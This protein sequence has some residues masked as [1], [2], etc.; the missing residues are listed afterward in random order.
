VEKKEG[1]KMKRRIVAFMLALFLT[2]CVGVLQIT[3]AHALT[4]GPTWNLGPINTIGSMTGITDIYGLTYNQNHMV[5]GVALN[6]SV[7]STH[8]FALNL[9]SHG[10]YYPLTAMS[11]VTDLG[12]SP[13][14]YWFTPAPAQPHLLGGDVLTPGYWPVYTT[15]GTGY[16]RD[17]AIYGGGINWGSGPALI[18]YDIDSATFNVL[19]P[20]NGV[21]GFPSWSSHGAVFAVA[22]GVDGTIY[23]GTGNY[24]LGGPGFDYL[25]SYAPASGTFSY[26]GSAPATD[27]YISQIVTGLHGELYVLSQPSGTVLIF[28][29]LT[30]Q[31]TPF[32][33]SGYTAMTL[34]L[35][36]NLWLCDSSGNLYEY[37]P[38]Y[39]AITG[40][41][42]IT[43]LGTIVSPSTP[44]L[45]VYGMA[46]GLHGII[47]MAAYDGTNGY[48][49]VYDA[50]K[51]VGWV[52]GPRGTNG[53]G[54]AVNPATLLTTAGE[55]QY[56]LVECSEQ[57]TV[58]GGTGLSTSVAALLYYYYES[59]NPDL[60]NAGVVGGSALHLLA[61]YWASDPPA[62]S[63][64]STRDTTV[65]AFAVG[66]G[67]AACA[68]ILG[69]RKRQK[70]KT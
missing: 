49:V 24:L 59:G 44:T 8:L 50:R 68:I 12:A 63:I 4:F 2:L 17:L 48:L 26:I 40:L 56:S 55:A 43:K 18:V 54:L 66:L 1:E 5:Y 47:Y 6:P 19:T 34:D 37:T 21:S 16:D 3:P 7:P 62:K 70:K 42:T 51:P 32:P 61:L 45:T 52:P 35:H 60:Y 46:A 53:P 10:G 31:V 57:G 69:A 9:E 58:V 30:S 22:T 25:F 20:P 39:P 36:G 15:I 11:A 13:S 38:S 33:G 65:A 41:G 27:T 23:C 67:V 29:P 28:E 14:P 64:L